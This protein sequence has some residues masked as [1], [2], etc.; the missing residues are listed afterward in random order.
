MTEGELL[1]QL[2]E[3]ASLTQAELSELAGWKSDT[4]LNEVEKGKRPA[5]LRTIL[6]LLPHLG[7]SRRQ[8]FDLLEAGKAPIMTASEGSNT[9]PRQAQVR[10]LIRFL[11]RQGYPAADAQEIANFAEYKRLQLSKGPRS[12][13]PEDNDK[14]EVAQE[15]QASGLE[16]RM[17]A[18]P[19]QDRAAWVQDAIEDVEDPPDRA[20]G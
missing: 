1:R 16:L 17:P 7:V 8:F 18:Q 6:R 10:A 20:S 5:T 19:P 14:G 4:F 3:G 13:D 9:D 12:I 2:R 11:K 15:H